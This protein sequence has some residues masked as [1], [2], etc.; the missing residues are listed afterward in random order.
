[1]KQGDTIVAVNLVD[2]A[3]TLYTLG[4][5]FYDP[6]HPYIYQMYGGRKSIKFHFGEESSIEGVPVTT[7]LMK[8]WRGAE[9]EALGF[10]PVSICKRV[11]WTRR[12]LLRELNHDACPHE[13]QGL[14]KDCTTLLEVKQATIAYALGFTMPDEGNHIIEQDHTRVFQVG[15]IPPRW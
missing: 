10:D 8:G 2:L 4:V 11:I 6:D 3:I 13:L 1:M 12:N 9:D 7:D 5:S 15:T 14:A